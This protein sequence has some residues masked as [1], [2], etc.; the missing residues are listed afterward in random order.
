M[1]NSNA[2]EYG[3]QLMLVFK[4]TNWASNPGLGVQCLGVGM[5][6]MIIMVELANCC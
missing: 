4:P 3:F 5:G 1:F 6:V 2:N